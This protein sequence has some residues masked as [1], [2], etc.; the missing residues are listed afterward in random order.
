MKFLT[1]QIVYFIRQPELR[2][3][4][5]GLFRYLII[6]T[7][8]IVLFAVLFHFIMLRFEG[9][10]HSWLTG[11]YWTLTVM[12]TLGF[13][14][15]TFHSDIGRAFSLIVLLSGIVLLLV[16]L[17]FTFI[18]LFYAPWLEAQLHLRSPRSV[19]EEERDH[20]IICKLDDIA[21]GLINRLK[22][23]RLPYYLLEPDPQR[24]AALHREG[25]SVVTGEID[26]SETYRRLHV[27]RARFVFANL[28][29]M[30]NSNVTLTVREIAPNV[31]VAALVERE[32]SVDVLELSGATHVL[33]LK[34]RL[35]EHLANRVNAGESHAH[36]IGTFRDH[37]IAEFSAQ[38]AG[39]SGMQ[40]RD[41]RLRERTGITIVGI[42][43]KDRI[44]PA[45]P[46]TTLTEGSVPIIIGTPDQIKRLEAGFTPAENDDGPIL[47]IGG[48][49]VG[50]AAARSLKRR[51]LSVHLIERKRELGPKLAGIA[52]KCHFGDAADRA[53]LDEAGLDGAPSVLLTT[54]DDATNIFLAVYCRRLR[55]DIQIISRST[56]D[57]NLE[58]LYRA[59]ANVVLSYSALGVETIFSLIQSRPPMILGAST[60]F[61]VVPLPESLEGTS[62]AESN[63]GAKTGLIVIA[64]D[65]NGKVETNPAPSL[66]LT[67]SSKLLML[68]TSEQRRTF[69]EIYS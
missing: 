48:G 54:H 31:P 30:T 21:P 33:P 58:A 19:P 9:Q 5:R 57:R 25:L 4:L 23:N 43:E 67:S 41:T 34:Q 15:I 2:E 53:L 6:L 11:V 65:K 37:L 16:M 18:R 69:S 50:R 52:D 47:I 40:V 10:E 61:F 24:A 60:E 7:G 8:V 62:L 32:D 49:K 38:R 39:L 27:E 63:I 12:S 51:G 17:P 36:T 42:W 59:G 14:D 45:H 22:V 68:G 29:D 26:N 46:T 28:D 1:S 56:H 66:I 35:G 64:V 20:V 13:G 44:R 3:N 55:P